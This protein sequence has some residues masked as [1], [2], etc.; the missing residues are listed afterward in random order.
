MDVDFARQLSRVRIHV[1][2]V[3][4]FLRQKYTILEPINMIMCP[5]NSDNISV[6]D[7]IVTVCSALCNE[8]VGIFEYPLSNQLW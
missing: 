6:I 3:I 2:R 7:K 8:N 1:E 4:G 5:A